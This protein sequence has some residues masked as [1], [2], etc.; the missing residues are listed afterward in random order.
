MLLYFRLKNYLYNILRYC[1]IMG[2][3]KLICVFDDC[4]TVNILVLG[5]CDNGYYNKDIIDF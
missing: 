2:S 3:R 5:K 4:F 1:L